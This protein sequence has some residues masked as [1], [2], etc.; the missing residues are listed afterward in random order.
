MRTQHLG[1][2]DLLV[3]AKVELDS[4]LLFPEVAAAID[5]AEARVRRRVPTARVIYLE[6]DVYDASREESESANS[7][8]SREESESAN[9]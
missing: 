6:P 8:A 9:D 2:D 3:A 5:R 7:D 4:T 1:P